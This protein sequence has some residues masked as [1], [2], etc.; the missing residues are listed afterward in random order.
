M[1]DKGVWIGLG[2]TL[3]LLVHGGLIGLTDDEAYYWVLA[4]KLDWSYAFHP[5]AVAWMIRLSQELFGWL[6][7]R[8][9]L[10][11][12]LPAALN[13]GF[14]VWLATSWLRGV[15]TR[16][17]VAALS[18][19][20]F[21]CFF[22]LGWMM[23]PDHPLFLGWTLLFVLTSRFCGVHRPG[24]GHADALSPWD[25]IS[26]AAGAFLLLMSK[27]S[28]IL[29]IGSSLL[30]LALWAPRSCRNKALGAVLFGTVAAVVPI[31]I[32]NA[33][34]GWG[35]L[36]YQLRDRHSGAEL[37][38]TRWFRFLGIQFLLVGP[39][40]FWT[41]GS[42]ISKGISEMAAWLRGRATQVPVYAFLSLWVLPAAFVY[43]VQPLFAEFKPH[44]MFIA[45]WPILFGFVAGKKNWTGG[46]RAHLAYGMV[47]FGLILSACHYP[48]VT[49]LVGR[50]LDVTNDLY[51]WST[52]GE[53][54][55]AK[56][57][58]EVRELP[59]VGSRYQ[60]AAQLSFYLGAKRQVTKIPR[61]EKEMGEWPDLDSQ[62]V[63]G[64]GPNW[65][66]LKRPILF[67]GDQ[68][69]SSGPE[70]PGAKCEKK[71]Q[72]AVSRHSLD[73]KQ[74]DLWICLP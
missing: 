35:S 9:S 72:H 16:D 19:M 57:P 65:P 41:G 60:T 73:S 33:S 8:S 27:Y 43:G 22:G 26:L 46:L 55:D 44:W 58:Q 56:L 61:D 18:V 38:W 31:V 32:W 12:R 66:T 45:W 34:H 50:N 40:L 48:W 71:W 70:F 37:S 47:G 29:A 6:V 51:G 42:V 28:G 17:T 13:A 7:G 1:A 30:C 68:R 24:P 62:V 53:F 11:V 23:V 67:V 69:Y 59:V 49:Q 21:F 39:V 52:L 64:Q 10:L 4:Q 3:L 5:P 36:L 2:L 15:Q 63:D 14:L 20:G 54:M 25:W 74:I